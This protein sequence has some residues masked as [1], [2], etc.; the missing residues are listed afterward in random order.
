MYDIEAQEPS[1]EFERCWASAAQHLQRATGDGALRW[2]KSTLSP[3]F[4]EHLSFAVGNQLF[5]IRVEDSTGEVTGPGSIDSLKR[6]AEKSNGIPCLMPMDRSG[7]DWQPAK[8]GWGLI[9][10]GTGKSV[11]PLSLITDERIVMTDWEV[12]DFAVQVVREHIVDELGF[13][14]RSSQSDP[15]VHPAIWFEGEDGPEWVVVGAVRYPAK[16]A[17]LPQNISE[18]AVHC[19][20]MSSSGH[21]ASVSVANSEDPFDPEETEWGL[22]LWRGY[23]LRVRFSGLTPAISH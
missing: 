16:E 5:F 7:T 12:H 18:I 14:L 3:P 9:G 11:D 22:P 17:A 2:L 23:G 21:F 20:R 10:L 19:S 1:H 13:K 4:M 8:S 15:E 6:V